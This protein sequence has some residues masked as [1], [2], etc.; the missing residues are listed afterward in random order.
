MLLGVGGGVFDDILDAD[1]NSCGTQLPA[2]AAAHD[3]LGGDWLGSL[4]AQHSGKSQADT[5]FLGKLLRR[6][7]TE[8]RI[9]ERRDRVWQ[10]FSRILL[11]SRRS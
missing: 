5:G 11:F 4:A 6:K 9:S 2:S 1:A 10:R 3:Y 8:S 7:G